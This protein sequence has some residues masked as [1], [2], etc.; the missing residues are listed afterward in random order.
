VST[1]NHTVPEIRQSLAKALRGAIDSYADDLRVLR[2]RELRKS[3]KS[4]DIGGGPLALSEMCKGGDMCKGDHG[5]CKRCGRPIKTVE[6]TGNGLC[7]SCVRKPE[8]KKGEPFTK[9]GSLP[10]PGMTPPKAPKKGPPPIPADA[11]KTKKGEKEDLLFGPEPKKRDVLPRGPSPAANAKVGATPTG[12]CSECGGKGHGPSKHAAKKDE[13]P[14][15]AAAPDKKA[16]GAKLPGDKA[17]KVVASSAGTGGDVTKGKSLKKDALDIAVGRKPKAAAA[18]PPKVPG[19]PGKQ[20]VGQ[21]GGDAPGATSVAQANKE[22]GRMKS[23]ATNPTAMPTGAVPTGVPKA[24][25]AIPTTGKGPDALSNVRSKM[26][27]QADMK[28]GG[29]GWLQRLVASR[30]PAP[31]VQSAPAGGTSPF[32]RSKPSPY[33][34]VRGAAA[35]ARGEMKDADEDKE[36]KP[37]DKGLA[38]T[39]HN[40]TLFRIR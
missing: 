21:G 36:G 8:V 2:E 16:S 6:H 23:V 27:V 9:P 4:E 1:K 28:A 20:P 31:Q 11:M 25:A 18:A 32:G 5:D 30:K 3:K 37:I 35:L 39:N 12:T 19:V 22:L 13:L 33:A 14:I 7:G 29:V 38:F 15:T 10:L 40:R 26:N 34:G 24:A 17:S